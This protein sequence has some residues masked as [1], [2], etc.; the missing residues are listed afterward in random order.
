MLIEGA[1]GVGK[2]L[3]ARTIHDM[4][5][6]AKGRFV[7][8]D[9][10]AAQE[11][12]I[13][14]ELFGHERHAMPGADY[15]R[16]GM[17]EIANGGTIYLNDVDKLPLAL[18]SKIL[19]VMELGQF[20]RLGGVQNIETD[21]RIIA[22]TDC[23]LAP[24]V[25]EGRFRSEFY[26]LLNAFCLRVPALADR[27]GDIADLATYFL[28]GTH[29]ALSDSALSALMAYAWPGNIR[30]LK[31][32]IEHALIM[33]DSSPLIE[34]THLLIGTGPVGDGQV[35]YRLSYDYE[36]TLQQLRDDYIAQLLERH[37]G[38]RSKVAHALGISERNLYRILSKTA[39]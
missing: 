10:D 4:S 34:P 16:E 11:Q 5:P 28:R 3:A 32:V 36:P 35:Q 7:P 6:R 17:F 23:D 29:K 12:M 33:S 30:E 39:S 37:G 24:A 31:N 22:A 18:Q 26:Y 20:R 15:R 19:R 25:A 27:K 9:C 14:A 8:M 1:S 13:T 2:E 38:N 21:V